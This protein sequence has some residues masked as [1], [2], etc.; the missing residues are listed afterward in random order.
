VIT[1][2]MT[3]EQAAALADFARACKAATR[4]VS[5]YPGT[6]PA[7]QVSLNRLVSAAG[8][9]TRTGDAQLVVHPT[10]LLIGDRAAARPDSSIG[11]L[12]AMLHSRLVGSIR[13]QAGVEAEDWRQFLLLLA[14]SLDE[15]IE[16]G[17]IAKAW[18][19]TGR[20]HVDI[21]EIDYASV[22]KER[23]KGDNATWDKVLQACLKGE[24]VPLDDAV[25]DTLLAAVQDSSTFGS[26]LERL[27]EKADTDGTSAS[28]QV[29]ALFQLLKA[30]LAAAEARQMPSRDEVLA[31]V[32]ESSSH[33]TP[34]M[35]LGLV[36]QRESTSTEDSHLAN[37]IVERMTDDSIA[38]FVARSVTTGRGASARLAQA[39][40]A[41]VPDQNRKMELLAQ[42]HDEAMAGELGED[43]NFE[44][45]W[46][47]AAKSMLA[48][49]SDEGFVPS[50]YAREL[51]AA[52]TQ[53][54]EV[55]RTSDDPPERIADW[56]GTVSPRAMQELDLNLTLDLL[57]IENDAETWETIG[58]LAAREIERCVLTGDLVFAQRLA[59]SLQEAA[60]GERPAL[61]D[62][63]RRVKARLTAGALPKHIV[64][65]L[66]K[67]PES[68]VAALGRLCQAVGP[69]LVR[70]FAESLANE[71]HAHTIRR[72]RELLI[73]FG[74]AG[75]EAVEP[76]KNSSNPA[77]RRTAVDLLRVFGGNEALHELTAMLSDADPQVQQDSIRAIV[78]IGT[79]EAYGTL[80][81]A[82]SSAATRDMVVRELVSLRDP[83]TI[84]P[85]CFVL[86]S[87]EPTA[88]VAPQHEA[89]IEALSS[90]RAHPDSTAALRTALHRGAW[91][92]PRRTSRLRQAAAKG[93]R[94]LGSED[95]RAALEEAAQTGTRGV[96]KVA[97]EELGAMAA[98]GSR[99]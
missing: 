10:A 32:A 44:N 3:Q 86:T 99:S 76:L 97:G 91:W 24:S 30:V 83:K 33:L 17:G 90:L 84:P 80:E 26:L 89:I 87:T 82:C 51:T 11:E 58:A 77:V 37:G 35:I 48:T 62:G 95:A 34:E 85:L 39:F 7:I 42:A 15:L 54:I 23:N 20:G 96:R 71:D 55:E 6:H 45:I 92:A 9:L 12:A 1:E 8:V 93:L 61:Q 41:L 66:R 59:D 70:P 74:P 68:E 88:A 94:R 79:K 38:A 47:D 16:R 29:A 31:T 18:A 60:G 53:A 81:K 72:L 43:A 14:S 75:R 64:A 25:I 50:D 13:V 63:A 5:L 40:E 36:A 56:L 27:Q 98:A 52:R 78:Q 19:A 69:A 2:P 46:Q 28:A 21:E 65:H 49:Y 73:N 4:A 67:A 22:L 57:R